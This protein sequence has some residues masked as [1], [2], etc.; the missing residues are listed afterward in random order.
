MERVT[1]ELKSDRMEFTH[2]K[3]LLKLSDLPNGRGKLAA[4]SFREFSDKA[5]VSQ[6]LASEGLIKFDEAIATFTGVQAVI[7]QVEIPQIFDIKKVEA[8][9]IASTGQELLKLKAN[10]LPISEGELKVLEKLAELGEMLKPTE[11]DI[12][13][14]KVGTK[15]MTAGDRN[16]A[17]KELY[18]RGF[19]KVYFKPEKAKKS[20]IAKPTKAKA[21]GEFQITA[22]GQDCLL[23]LNN[24]F[25]SLRNSE[26]DITLS[27]TT[28]TIIKPSDAEVL[29]IIRELGTK[30]E[31]ENYLPIFFLRER[32]PT[33][34]REELDQILYRLVRQKM[35]KL[36]ALSEIEKY[37]QSQINSGIPQLSGGPK[38]FIRVVTN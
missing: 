31:I 35:I 38:F 2:L 22:K 33:L 17:L 34:S 23:K 9:G 12:K 7:T 14:I 25:E 1:T 24:Y 30:A 3:F 21:S 10:D 6:D 26:S 13:A 28:G 15:K 4:T 19:I 37:T 8:V 36:T 29:E 20:A 11:I 32:L 5:Q 27:K 16:A 18:E